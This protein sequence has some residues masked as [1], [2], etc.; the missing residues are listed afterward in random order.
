MPYASNDG[1]EIFYDVEGPRDAPVVTFV[2]G[3]S[4]GTWMW[5][6]QR[7]DLR[8]DYR[9]IVFDNRGTGD[10]DEPEGPYTASG[11]ASDLEAVLDDAGVDET[12]VVGASLG[13]MIAQQYALEYDR[14]ASLVL[15]CTTPG[16]E[17]AV[18][19]PEETLDRMLNVPA[20]YGPAESIRHKMRPAFTDE[21]WEENEAVVDRI[22][23]W[24]LET[25][26]SERAYEWQ[27]AA[28]SA[29]D[30]SERLGE[31]D[32]P[33][34]LIHG[35][36]DRVVPFANAELLAEGLSDGELRAD[37][38]NDGIREFLSRE[39]ADRGAGSESEGPE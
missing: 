32:Q 11:M 18:P 38:V 21:F 22:V 12:H 16:G 14:A 17:D 35:T 1:V 23:E 3:L 33:T 13:G 25:D 15:V 4:Y 27:T 36:A 39:T 6:W 9:T 34:L 20:E 24:R 10:S 37:E 30:A 5:R 8:E 29:F 7:D 19:I 2:E 31:I 28:A 26:P